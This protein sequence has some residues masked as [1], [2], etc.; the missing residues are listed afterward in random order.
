M[1][2]NYIVI[3]LVTAAVLLGGSW[4][5]AGGMDW[6]RT[7]KLPALAPPGSFIGLAWTIIFILS[8]VSALIFW[9]R[10]QPG[11]RS[12]I[13]ALFIAN[14]LFN[15][16]WSLIFF[17]LHLIG[18]S[19]IEMT[20]LNLTTLTLITLLWK[21]ALVPALLLIPYFGWVSFATYLAYSIWTLN[22]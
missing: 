4:L 7:L 13:A 6:Y 1:K 14:A 18:L 17:R 20:A 3:P 19:I 11:T 5:T 9:N 12:T 2:L 16:C 15:V 22:K 8:T 10:F 21:P